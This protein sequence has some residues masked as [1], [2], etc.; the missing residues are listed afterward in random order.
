MDELNKLGSLISL[1][2]KE[3]VREPVT[4]KVVCEIDKL[5]SELLLS[6]LEL[7][8]TKDR[9]LKT[10]DELR[11]IKKDY[12]V[13]RMNCTN[14]RKIMLLLSVGLIHQGAA[15]SWSSIPRTILTILTRLKNI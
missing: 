6:T 4:T 5:K 9:L 7:T 2:I 10:E 14:S 11:Q 3:V 13:D 15:A 1:Y 8:N 12:S